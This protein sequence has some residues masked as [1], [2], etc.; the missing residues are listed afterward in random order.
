MC[1]FAGPVGRVDDDL[2]HVILRRQEAGDHRQLTRRAR[3][4]PERPRRRQRR[5]VQRRGAL[6]HLHAPHHADRVHRHAEHDLA[7]LLRRHT[8]RPGHAELLGSRRQ[9]LRARCGD[10]AHGDNKEAAR[11]SAG[12]HPIR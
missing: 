2:Q 6:Q 5:L 12:G 9:L 10:A 8:L 7:P 3:L 11:G 1:V 4:E